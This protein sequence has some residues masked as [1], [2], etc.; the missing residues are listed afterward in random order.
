MSSVYLEEVYQFAI[1]LA[2]QAGAL[3]AE[4]SASRAHSAQGGTAEATK[5][6]RGEHIT[7]LWDQSRYSLAYGE[8]N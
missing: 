6:N 5:K 8:L 2:R 7:P 1:S 3:I 4:A